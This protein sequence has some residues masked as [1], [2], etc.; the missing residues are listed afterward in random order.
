MEFFRT[1]NRE[2]REEDIQHLLTLENLENMTDELFVIGDQSDLQ[3]EIGGL[4]G[5]FTLT[6]SP[7]RG[8]L[9]FALVECPN[10]LAWTIT[11]GLAPNPEEIVIHLTIN[12]KT[13]RKPFI[14]EINE[15]L[16]DHTEKLSAFFEQIPL[17]QP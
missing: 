13:Q 7:I 9:R 8:G 15:F 10:A 6:R 2:T 11:T 14:Q 17:I 16:D 1:I 4:W 3:A 5:E 12:R